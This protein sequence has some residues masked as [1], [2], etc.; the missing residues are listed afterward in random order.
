MIYTV[1]MESLK[2][3]R[4]QYNITQQQLERLINIQQSNIARWE[5]GRVKLSELKLEGIKAI[6]INKFKD[7]P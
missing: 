3:L 5:S 4:K 1:S 2:D 7:T 6:L